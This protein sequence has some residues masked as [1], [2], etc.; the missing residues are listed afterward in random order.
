M[1]VLNAAARGNERPAHCLAGPFWIGRVPV[2]NRQRHAFI[3]DDGYRRYSE[4]FFDG[5]YKVVRGGSWAAAVAAIRPCSATGTTRSGGRS[6]PA[7]GWPGT[8]EW[9]RAC[10]YKFSAYSW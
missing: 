1:A 5:D 7:C 2:I 3:A 8:P 9:C 10:A 6:S 4:P